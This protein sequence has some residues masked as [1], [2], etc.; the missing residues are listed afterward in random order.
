[1]WLERLVLKA[2]AYVSSVQ[3]VVISYL[4]IHATTM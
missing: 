4:P 2:A 1:M 3:P